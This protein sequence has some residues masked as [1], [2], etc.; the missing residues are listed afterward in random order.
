MHHFS[1]ETFSGRD[2]DGALVLHANVDDRQEGPGVPGHVDA[3]HLRVH[4][5]HIFLHHR[6][7]RQPRKVRTCARRPDQSQMIEL[8]VLFSNFPV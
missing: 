1:D 2:R 8:V 7:R 6:G 4:H 5:R 3:A